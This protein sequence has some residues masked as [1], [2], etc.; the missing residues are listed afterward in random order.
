LFAQEDRTE[1]RWA[2]QLQSLVSAGADVWTGHRK[3]R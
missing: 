2:L 3:N 1:A